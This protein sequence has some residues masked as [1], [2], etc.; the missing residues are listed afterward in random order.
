M[1]KEIE[2][3]IKSKKKMS[4]WGV[5]PK[6]ILYLLPFIVLF[7]IIHFYFFPTFQL[8]I[9][10]FYT[11]IIGIILLMLGFII[12][13]KTLK[14]INKAHSESR[15]VTHGIYAYVRH[16]LYSSF[17]LF[18]TPGIVLLFNSYILFFIPII[19]YIIFRIL[20]RKEE[21]YCLNQF[22]ELYVHY[23]KNLNAIF[24]KFRKYKEKL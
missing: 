7:T 19:Y 9:N 13:I 16:P 24:P 4:K 14:I 6:M 5:S 20:I 3:K 18:M 11:I 17:I 8:P 15:L 23:K 12:Y 2:M 21:M 22:G 10:P 1:V